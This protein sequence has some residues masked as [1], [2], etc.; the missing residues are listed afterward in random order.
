MLFTQ[1][2]LN[3]E[4]AVRKYSIIKVFL[5]I[6][7][8]SQ[9]NTCVLVSLNKVAGL[10]PAQ[11]FSCE[12][13]E[14]FKNLLFTKHIRWLLLQP[15]KGYVTCKFSTRGEI[16]PWM[17]S[18]LP[19]VKA[20]FVVTCWNESKFQPYG[21]FNSVVTTGL[22]FQLGYNSAC[23][24]RLGLRQIASKSCRIQ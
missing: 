22:K 21:C 10:T 16:H 12:F 4:A 2:F 1:I 6:S 5:D 9:K 3:P 14:I 15:A 11:M 17:N 7:Q 23:F 19:M 8:N 24:S 18:T 20:L 13:G